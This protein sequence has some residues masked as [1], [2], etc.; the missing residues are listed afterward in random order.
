[1]AQ[2]ENDNSLA[3]YNMSTADAFALTAGDTIVCQV[4]VFN[5]GS[6]NYNIAGTATTGMN[7]LSIVCIG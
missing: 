2:S 6:L 5:S 3:N 1:M 7:Y 4:A